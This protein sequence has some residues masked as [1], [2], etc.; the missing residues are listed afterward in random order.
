M[1]AAVVGPARMVRGF[2]LAGI[3]D[4]CI[5][6]DAGEAREAV[7][8]WLRDT[9]I[10]IIITTPPIRKGLSA[11]IGLAGAG[12]NAYP[13][14]ISLPGGKDDEEDEVEDYLKVTGLE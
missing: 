2:A 4:T 8:R 13:V 14:I 1:R 5:A 12:K 3:K 11:E 6:N 9:G 10:G 7:L